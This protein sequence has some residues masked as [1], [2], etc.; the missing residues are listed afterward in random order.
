MNSAG[1]FRVLGRTSDGGRASADLPRRTD[2][3]VVRLDGEAWME[4][5]RT[6]T[7]AG[8]SSSL[9]PERTGDDVDHIGPSWPCSGLER[10]RSPGRSERLRWTQRHESDEHRTCAPAPPWEGNNA[11]PVSTTARWTTPPSAPRRRPFDER[12]ACF[13]RPPWPLCR[14]EPSGHMLIGGEDRRRRWIV[15]TDFSEFSASA[16]GRTAQPPLRTPRRP[17]HKRA[18]GHRAGNVGDQARHRPVTGRVQALRVQALAEL[19]VLRFAQS[20]LVNENH[21]HVYLQ[22]CGLRHP[23]VEPSS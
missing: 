21:R 14:R 1:W 16:S 5:G 18:V 13:R 9:S 20:H 17:P 4:T 11:A 23:R 7:S 8:S 10:I 12:Q 15:D 22:C 2:G 3:G 6:S 19:V